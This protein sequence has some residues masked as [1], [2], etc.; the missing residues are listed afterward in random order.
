MN[1]KKGFRSLVM[2]TFFFITGAFFPVLNKIILKAE[3]TY[4]YGFTL[5]FNKPWFQVFA[6]NFGMIFYGIP[7]L[8]HFFKRKCNKNVAMPKLFSWEIFRRCGLPSIL[9]IV[10]S[11]LQTYSLLTMPVSVWQIFHGF[12]VLF[13]TLFAVTVLKQRLFLVDWLGVFMNVFGLSFSGVAV[14]LRGISKQNEKIS[15]QFIMMI[16]A[17]ISH[18][19]KSY[20]RGE[21]LLR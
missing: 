13:T 10:A 1:F 16:L 4:K 19:I 21:P 18:G 8:V 9:Y 6:L 12:Q 11:V 17:I 14:L 15:E 20:Q 2:I 3:F 5:G 7:F